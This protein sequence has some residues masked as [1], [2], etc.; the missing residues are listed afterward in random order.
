MQRTECHGEGLVL[1]LTMFYDYWLDT[2]ELYYFAYK[3]D[4]IYCILQKN[5][6]KMGIFIFK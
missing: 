1:P 4:V 5:L 2:R 6:D 3:A